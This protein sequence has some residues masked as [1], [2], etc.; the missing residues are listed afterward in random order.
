MENA[1]CHV[2]V[3]AEEALTFIRPQSGGIYIDATVG[4]G[5]HAAMILER[6]SPEGFLLGIDRDAEALTAAAKKL[7]PYQGRFVLVSGNYADMAA[8]AEGQGIEAADGILLDIGV[9]SRHLDAPERGFSYM[10]DAPLDMR[11]DQSSGRSAAEL[12]NEES[13]ETLTRILF[14]FG[15]EKWAKRIAEF[16]VSARAIK[17]I[18]T[19]GELVAIVKQAI[20]KGAR[21]KDQHPARRTF[22]A[23]RIA[24]NN[25]LS[26]LDIGLDAAISLLRPGGVIAVIS[27]H[28]L[29]DR[30][31]KTKLKHHATDCICPPRTPVCLCHHRAD[32]KLLTR[33]P[34]TAGSEELMANPR[35]RSAML[36]AAQ[37]L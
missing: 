20:P 11:M 2:P 29:E 22:Q 17:P 26:A 36:R 15:E 33:K 34:V 32:L 8:L 16:I 6:S 13:A 7:A 5:N 24:V 37:K 3:L 14:E 23:I 19:T 30:I 27:F 1:F 10:Q 21:E 9:S 28:S 12:V 4:G 18:D 35:S 31:V 25:E